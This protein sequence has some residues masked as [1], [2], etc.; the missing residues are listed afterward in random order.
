MLTCSPKSTEVA[1]TGRGTV[2]GRE[3]ARYTDAGYDLNGYRGCNLPKRLSYHGC[4]SAIS[5]AAHPS[6]IQWQ[7]ENRYLQ[8][9]HWQLNKKSSRTK[10]EL[11]MGDLI[12]SSVCA[13][14]TMQP[15]SKGYILMMI[16]VTHTHTHIWPNRHVW[17]DKRPVTIVKTAR[18]MQETKATRVYNIYMALCTVRGLLPDS[19]C[20]M[21]LHECQRKR[22]VASSETPL[23]RCHPLC[24]QALSMEDKL[25]NPPNVEP[26]GLLWQ[27]M[28]GKTWLGFLLFFVPS[29]LSGRHQPSTWLNQPSCIHIFIYAHTV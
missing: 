11:I 21:K 26:Q 29:T 7:L 1:I 5:P 6:S 20:T 3:T 2:L 16:N 19:N 13:K 14:W 8:N 24:F 25:S 9:G 17:I 10:A 15:R 4:I 27:G 12:P 22:L 18:I 23:I 28:A